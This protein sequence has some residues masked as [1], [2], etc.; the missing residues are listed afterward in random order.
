VGVEKK[1]LVLAP[2]L[3]HRRSCRGAASFNPTDNQKTIAER[4]AEVL[5]WIGTSLE[6]VTASALEDAEAIRN[7]IG[8]SPIGSLNKIATAGFLNLKEISLLNPLLQMSD[9]HLPR[10]WLGDMSEASLLQS[11]ASILSDLSVQETFDELYVGE[12]WVHRFSEAC[13]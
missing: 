12:Q 9:L 8:Q 3:L 4:V 1:R 6:Q 11:D 7:S 10:A 2:C 5:T 13:M